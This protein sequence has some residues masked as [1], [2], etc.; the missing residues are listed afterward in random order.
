[1]TEPF[2]RSGEAMASIYGKADYDFV[3]LPHP[4]GNTEPVILKKWVEKIYPTVKRL[5]VEK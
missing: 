2:V 4:I 1:M 5:L 3:V